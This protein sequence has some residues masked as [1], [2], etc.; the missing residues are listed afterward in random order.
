MFES[1][2][3]SLLP[4][5]LSGTTSVASNLPVL[6]SRRGEATWETP[7][8]KCSTLSANHVSV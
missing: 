2:V 1:K 7:I 6:F 8:R 5:Y 3:E 4:N